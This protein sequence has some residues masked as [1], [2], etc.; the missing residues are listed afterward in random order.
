MQSNAPSRPHRQ[1]RE[2]APWRGDSTPFK[3]P[4]WPCSRSARLLRLDV[5]ALLDRAPKR[6]VRFLFLI[7]ELRFR[8]IERDLIQGN[9]VGRARP[10]R[11]VVRDEQVRERPLQIFLLL[12]AGFAAGE[13]GALDV[14]AAGTSEEQLRT[15]LV[16]LHDKTEVMEGDLTGAHAAAGRGRAALLFAPAPGLDLNLAFVLGIRA[17]AF[18]AI[19]LQKIVNDRHDG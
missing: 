1:A 18:Y 14:I 8:E 19:N 16:H 15:G 12:F 13:N 2:C 9:H 4:L 3:F 7:F 11:L 5:V 17:L 6:A 10:T